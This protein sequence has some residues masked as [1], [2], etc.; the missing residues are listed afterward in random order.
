MN[1]LVSSIAMY[2][3]SLLRSGFKSATK[4]FKRIGGHIK[5]RSKAGRDEVSSDTV[6]NTKISA[7]GRS[8]PVAI[9]EC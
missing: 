4:T 9:Q 1:S 8:K 3:G 7:D 6:V 2:P 5:P